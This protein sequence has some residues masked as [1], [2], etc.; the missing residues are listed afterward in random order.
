MLAALGPAPCNLLVD[1]GTGTGRTLELFADRYK[2]GLG[3]DRNTAMLAYARS[4]LDRA[5]ITHAQVRQGDIYDLPLADAS[6]DV[7]VV[8]QILHFLTDPAGA[9]REAARVL[10]PGGRLM[11]VDFA[12]H[13]LEFLRETQA[14]ERLGFADATITQWLADRRLDADGDAASDAAAR[15]VQE[16]HTR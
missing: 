9:I 15:A 5:Q 8:H 13:E 4:K 3:F 2:R 12:P 6:A 16:R 1:L 7:V 11:I 10:A 14:H